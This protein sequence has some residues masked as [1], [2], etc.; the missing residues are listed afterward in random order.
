M[1]GAAASRTGGEIGMLE[2]VEVNDVE[3]LRL[4]WGATL[5]IRG[6]GSCWQ[7]VRRGRVGHVLTRASA[8]GLAM[9]LL[10]SHG[11]PQ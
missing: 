11:R 7:A 8:V 6:A 5:D 4:G 2:A 10:I 9:A 3:A 1:G